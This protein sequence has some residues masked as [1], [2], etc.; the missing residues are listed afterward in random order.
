MKL[1]ALRSGRRVYENDAERAETYAM[2][3]SAGYTPRWNLEDVVST[4]GGVDSSGLQAER[5][6]GGSQ[7][8]VYR[9]LELIRRR[10]LD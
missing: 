5:I 10:R 1:L 7:D 9:V 6:G 2:K 8:R 3:S 4:T